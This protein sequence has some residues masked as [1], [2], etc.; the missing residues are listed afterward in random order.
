MK[1]SLCVFFFAVPVLY[2][3]ARP[4]PVETGKLIAS[5]REAALA[6]DSKLPDFIC[7]QTTR[8]EERDNSGISVTG[9]G[10]FGRA[11]ANMEAG[12]KTVDSMEEQLTYFKRQESYKILAVNGK[13]VSPDK[14]TDPGLTTRGEFGS[15]LH[16]VFEPESFA[17][18]KWIRREV[19]RRQ[20]MQVFSYSVRR[21]DSAVTLAANNSK[22]VVGYRGLVFVDR[23][24]N[25]VMR[26][27]V[28]PQVPDSFPMQEVTR[29]L[30]YGRVTIVGESYLVPLRAE[31]ESRVSRDFLQGG[32]TDKTSAKV[33]LRNT[34]DFKAYRKYRVESAFKPE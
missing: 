1:T 33:H 11:L 9:N 5:V 14:K 6:Y 13:A 8:R 24:T 26:L 21:E 30:D 12:W 28:E 2:A 20:P 15:T 27:T 34:V 23:E 16:N 31:T 25:Q 32:K 22:V 18:I 29:T 3:Q 4:S 19:L 17:D 7:T 10:W